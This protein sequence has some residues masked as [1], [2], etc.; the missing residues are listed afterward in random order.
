MNSQKETLQHEIDLLERELENINVK[1]LIKEN[2]RR[3][4]EYN[5]Y[6]DI[7]QRIFGIIAEKEGCTVREIYEKF[8][9]EETD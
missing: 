7:G 8:G 2:M 1:E 5:K 6:K 4:H 9:I 3:L